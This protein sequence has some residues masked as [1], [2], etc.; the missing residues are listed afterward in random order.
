MSRLNA[1]SNIANFNKLNERGYT[2]NLNNTKNVRKYEDALGTTSLQQALSILVNKDSTDDEKAGAINDLILIRLILS[3]KIKFRSPKF[4][5]LIKQTVGKGFEGVDIRRIDRIDEI[6]ETLENFI[7]DLD[8]NPGQEPRIFKG[9]LTMLITSFVTIEGL[10]IVATAITIYPYYYG[11][12]SI[13]IFLNR[14]DIMTPLIIGLLAS[15]IVST[16]IIT[17]GNEL[18]RTALVKMIDRYMIINKEIFRILNDKGTVPKVFENDGPAMALYNRYIRSLYEIK[19]IR[20]R[21]ECRGYD[22]IPDKDCFCLE[23][24]TDCT[25]GLPYQVKPCNHAFHKTCIERW[26]KSDPRNKCPMCNGPIVSLD[27]AVFDKPPP[28]KNL[29]ANNFAQQI[30]QGEQALLNAN[31]N[32]AHE[33]WRNQENKYRKNPFNPSNQ[34][35][36]TN[37]NPSDNN[38]NRKLLLSSRRGGSTRKKRSNKKSK[39]RSAR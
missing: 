24:L 18:I 37:N 10:F 1:T 36:E 34:N 25:N 33:Q 35:N 31:A 23:P 4:G 9:F 3:G 21:K 17:A 11:M 20:D 16:A 13:A 12:R 8:E 2:V 19:I 39:T 28:F 7:K 15:M 22:Y 14:I 26:K 29:S 30:K 27:P 38:N 32:E 5:G 6:D